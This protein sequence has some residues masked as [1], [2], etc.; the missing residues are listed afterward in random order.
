MR[1]RLAGGV[2]ARA[3]RI[4]VC[5][6]KQVLRQVADADVTSKVHCSGGRLHLTEKNAEQTRFARAV[7]TD[8]SDAITGVNRQGHASKHIL[9]RKLQMNV[10]PL[11]QHENRPFC[12]KSGGNTQN[13]PV[14]KRRFGLHVENCAGSEEDAP[15]G[16]KL[17]DRNN[18]RNVNDGFFL[19]QARFAAASCF[20]G[21]PPQVDYA[22]TIALAR[23]RVK[24]AAMAGDI[25]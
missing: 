12:V 11:R 9:V 15:R 2:P 4:R 24:V 20:I 18:Q 21:Q 23:C 3:L 10:V 5:H 22:F 17:A 25:P 8:Q 16:R 7:F 1:E 13:G 14:K 19:I 6:V